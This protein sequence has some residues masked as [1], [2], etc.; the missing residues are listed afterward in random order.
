MDRTWGVVNP[1]PGFC[2]KCGAQMDTARGECKVCQAIEAPKPAEPADGGRR[3]AWKDSKEE[4]EIRLPLPQDVTKS[5]LR[6][7]YAA[8]RVQV[9]E[10]LE[11]RKLLFVEPIFDRIQPDGCNW[12]IEKEGTPD[13]VC[14]IELEKARASFWGAHL[15]ALGSD[16]EC[17]VPI[18]DVIGVDGKP[19]NSRR[20]L[21]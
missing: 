1:V 10:A 6:V 13:A 19:M 8:T 7:K 5:V 4:I 11:G 9:S 20:L 14:V 3:L 21:K 2:E 16:F 17:W 15:S 12:R 18:P